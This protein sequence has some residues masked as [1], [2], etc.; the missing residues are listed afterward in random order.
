MR[1]TQKEATGHGVHVFTSSEYV[2]VSSQYVQSPR[3]DT[4]QLAPHLLVGQ[5]HHHQPSL[6]EILPTGPLAD[7]SFVCITHMC[8]MCTVMQH[9][10]W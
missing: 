2:V 10:P 5:T 4:T 9:K 8:H 6:L 7:V 1:I 3:T